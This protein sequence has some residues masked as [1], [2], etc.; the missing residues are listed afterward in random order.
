MTLIADELQDLCMFDSLPL[1]TSIGLRQA[2]NKSLGLVFTRIEFHTQQRGQRQ[3][4][5]L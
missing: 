2:P 1:H 5:M 3:S 4:E